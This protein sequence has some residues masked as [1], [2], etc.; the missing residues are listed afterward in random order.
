MVCDSNPLVMWSTCGLYTALP[1]GYNYQRV[2]VAE[3]RMGIV[4]RKG[5]VARQFDGK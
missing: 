5:E 1:Y 3:D 2:G 4:D